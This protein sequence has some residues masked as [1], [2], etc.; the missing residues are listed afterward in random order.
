V[1]ID[2]VRERVSAGAAA[3]VAVEAVLRVL[4]AEATTMHP[5]LRLHW[6]QRRALREMAD[7]IRSET[8]GEQA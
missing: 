6:Y 7:S 2:H 5:E 3:R 4:A 8:K 1:L